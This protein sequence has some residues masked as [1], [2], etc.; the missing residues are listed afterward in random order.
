MIPFW[1]HISGKI[2]V[3]AQSIWCF[4]L[5]Y[6][7]M[8]KKI[9]SELCDKLVANLFM[10]VVDKINKMVIDKTQ[11]NMNTVWNNVFPCS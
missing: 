10:S 9:I 1:S 8:K 11:Y 2:E 6:I 4:S 3:A 7:M 5:A